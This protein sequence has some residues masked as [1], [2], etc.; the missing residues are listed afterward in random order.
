TRTAT[1]NKTRSCIVPS[2]E[3]EQNISGARNEFSQIN[4]YPASPNGPAFFR[5]G[6]GHAMPNIKTTGRYVKARPEYLAHAVQAI[7]EVMAEIG[8]TATRPIA[9]PA[10]NAARTRCTDFAPIGT[11]KS[12][13][14]TSCVPVHRDATVLSA[15]NYGAGEE[16][17]TLDPNLGKVVL[18]P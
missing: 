9:S 6:I 3:A 7:D 16:I 8:R 17:R 13:L 5:P 10:R 2:P 12:A 14:R 4:C 15:W 11:A 1:P 18:Y